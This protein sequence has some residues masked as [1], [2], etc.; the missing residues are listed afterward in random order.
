MIVLKVQ[1]IVLYNVNIFENGLFSRFWKKNDR[2]DSFE[3]HDI[4]NILI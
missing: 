3:M 2:N 1:M 4:N